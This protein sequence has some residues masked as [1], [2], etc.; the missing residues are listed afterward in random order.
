MFF[1]N[2]ALCRII[3]MVAVATGWLRPVLHFYTLAELVKRP[4]LPSL[5]PAGH[6]LMS[7]PL[8]A[9]SGHAAGLEVNR[10]ARYTLAVTV[11]QAGVIIRL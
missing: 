11:R 4:R 7:R 1:Y 5:G 2:R 10:Y 6:P 3:A 8:K 9:H